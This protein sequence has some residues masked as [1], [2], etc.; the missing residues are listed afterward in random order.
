[1][2]GFNSMN[3]SNSSS[4]RV[5]LNRRSAHVATLGCIFAVL[6]LGLLVEFFPAEAFFTELLAVDIRALFVADV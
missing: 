2:N 6:L 3:Q 5:A 4:A 1:M